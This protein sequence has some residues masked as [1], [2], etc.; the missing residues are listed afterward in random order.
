MYRGVP[1]I[2]VKTIVLVDMARAKPKSHSLTRPPA[3]TSTFC[4]F[5]SR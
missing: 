4:G 1:L 2:E 5:M 3:P